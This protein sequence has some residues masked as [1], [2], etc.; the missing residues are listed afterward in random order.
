M[1]QSINLKL[2]VNKLTWKK[3]YT[4]SSCSFVVDDDFYN[5]GPMQ[6]HESH[7][8]H[9][10]ECKVINKIKAGKARAWCTLGISALWRLGQEDWKFKATMGYIA[11]L[12]KE[13]KLDLVI[14]KWRSRNKATTTFTVKSWLVNNISRSCEQRKWEQRCE[15][16][17]EIQDKRTDHEAQSD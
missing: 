14:K 8:F 13:K 6:Q 3:T 16:L 5:D 2:Q 17:L 4:F 12:S 15:G 10:A 9:P 1:I 11:R 7:H